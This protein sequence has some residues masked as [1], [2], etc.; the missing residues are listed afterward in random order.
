MPVDK[1]L[2]MFCQK[3][4]CRAE[5]LHMSVLYVHTYML[6][7]GS[8]KKY[9]IKGLSTAGSEGRENLLQVALNLI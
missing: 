8:W 9:V 5:N 3:P 6:Y 1:A 2:K 4:I 7:A